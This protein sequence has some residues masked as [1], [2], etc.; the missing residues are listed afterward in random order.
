[1][2]TERWLT[3]R[4]AIITGGSRGIGAAIADALAQRGA[5]V[6]V[7][8]RDTAALEA[9]AARLQHHRV[10]A[11]AVPCDVTDEASV[12]AAFD[13]ALQ[14]FGAAYV[15]VNNAGQAEGAAFLETTREQWE[16]MLAANLTSAYLCT[17]RVLGGMLERGEGRIINVASTSGLR[18]Y[19]N[20]SAY[21]AAKHGLVGLTRALAAETVRNGITVNALCPAYTSTDMAER[22]VASVMQLGRTEEQARQAIARTVQR[23]TLIEPREVASAAAWLCSPDA[24]GITG[25]AIPIAGGEI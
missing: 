24:T 11:L 10:P 15:L 8:G 2:S 1:M 5:R 20:I 7:L 3:D 18:G 25:Q 6:T 17:Q 21:T 22:A 19:R 4:H 12:R 14:E 9:V 13:R 16:R 23:G